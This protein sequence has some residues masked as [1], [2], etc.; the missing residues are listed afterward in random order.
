LRKRPR[1]PD[2]RARRR[3]IN[4]NRFKAHPTQTNEG[5]QN[6]YAEETAGRTSTVCAGTAPRH[7]IPP[8]TR[9]PIVAEVNSGTTHGKPAIE[10]LIHAGRSLRAQGQDNRLKL[11]E[12]FHLLRNEC[13]PYETS[14]K[15]GL[16]YRQS[17]ARTGAARSTAERLRKMFETKE[18]YA[19]PADAFLRLCEEGVNLADMKVRHQDGFKGFI[20]PWIP[21]IQALDATDE[22]A[23]STLAEDIKAAEGTGAA[24]KPLTE[25]EAYI[26]ILLRDRKATEDDNQ[27]D[28]INEQIQE[29]RKQI[30]EIYI[31]WM[32]SLVAALTPFF[33]WSTKEVK[34]RMKAFEDELPLQRIRRYN[35]TLNFL[36]NIEAAF[37]VTTKAA[38]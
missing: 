35:E 9:P 21:K 22:K 31:R 5:Q 1:L 29:A 4:L 11:G 19:V 7:S 37:A 12:V 14:P 16:T 13:E 15:T 36:K 6:G 26:E 10:N 20:N 38:A 23:V 2:G 34:A 24:D 30:G 28:S 27:L 32:E 25:L 8:L 33:G 18:E 3:N 17:V